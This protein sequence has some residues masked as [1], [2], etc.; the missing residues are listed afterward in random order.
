MSPLVMTYTSATRQPS[1]RAS[2]YKNTSGLRYLHANRSLLQR[3][4]ICWETP[5]LSRR[6]LQASERLWEVFPY[7]LLANDGPVTHVYCRASNGSILFTQPAGSL[8]SP[9][10]HVPACQRATGSTAHVF[11]HGNRD[12]YHGWTGSTCQKCGTAQPRVPFLFS[13]VN[14]EVAAN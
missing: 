13:L 1:A 14:Q 5:H 3:R 12:C 9:C 10:H 7:L 8:G 2:V 4:P 6:Q 11:R